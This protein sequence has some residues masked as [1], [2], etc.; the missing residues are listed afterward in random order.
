MKKKAIL[1]ESTVRRFWKLANVGAINEMDYQF[2]EEI[3]EE[4]DDLEEVKHDKEDEEKKVDEGGKKEDDA[5]EVKESTEEELEEGGMGY[6][7]EDDEEELEE[8]GMDYA[9]E[10]EPMDDAPAMDDEPMADDGVEAEVSV[11]E[12]DVEALRTAA[13]VIDQ[14]LAAADSGE[15][16]MDMDDAPGDDEEPMMEEEDDDEGAMMESDDDLGLDEEKLEE[17][18]SAIADRV[19]ARIVKEALIKKLSK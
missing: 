4:E 5:E 13:K 19:K 10:D 9:R 17:M 2:G 7:K 14:I 6:K 3:N 11:P 1:N 8:G 18:V 12:S 15:G 16:D